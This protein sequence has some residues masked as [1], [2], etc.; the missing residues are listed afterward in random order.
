MGFLVVG[1]TAVCFYWVCPH[2]LSD[3]DLKPGSR[4]SRC[5]KRLLSD[6]ALGEQA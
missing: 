3:R 5:P 4:S 2:E 1:G 6:P